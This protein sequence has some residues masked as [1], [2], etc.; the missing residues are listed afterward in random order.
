MVLQLIN[1]CFITHHLF[2]PEWVTE[3]DQWGR[4]LGLET[5]DWLI[6]GTQGDERTWNEPVQP[7]TCCFRHFLTPGWEQREEG[8]CQ[9]I[10][11][12][13]LAPPSIWKTNFSLSMI[14]FSPSSW[15][16]NN[17]YWAYLLCVRYH[18]GWVVGLE[19]CGRSVQPSKSAKP[20]SAARKDD[21]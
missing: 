5:E 2:K 4:E 11:A 19:R 18:V 8:T 6:C 15:P 21:R 3:G 12:E 16:K 20:R 10:G 1:V 9:Q 13:A 14:F 17:F 7:V